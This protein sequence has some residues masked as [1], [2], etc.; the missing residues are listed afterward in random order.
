[1]TLAMA[2]ATAGGGTI[3]NDDRDV[4]QTALL[5]F[6]SHEEWFAGDWRPKNYVA[7]VSKGRPHVR[8]IFAQ[9]LASIRS[10]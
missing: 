10:Q 4:L 2:Q 9:A 7:I 8:P 6:F 3:T 5:S 1:M